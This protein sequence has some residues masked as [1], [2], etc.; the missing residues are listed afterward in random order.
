L[1]GGLFGSLRFLAVGGK[2]PAARALREGFNCV[3]FPSHRTRTGVTMP[4]K[5]PSAFVGGLFALLGALDRH[6]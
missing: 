3:V 6:G 4:V 1:R 2:M 5:G